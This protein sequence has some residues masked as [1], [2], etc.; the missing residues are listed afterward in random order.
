MAHNDPSDPATARKAQD[1]SPLVITSS[2]PPA[3]V[4]AGRGGAGNMLRDSSANKETKD[5]RG[6]S[7]KT[8]RSGS[9]VFV[10]AQDALDKMRS[11]SGR[12]R[13]SEAGSV[14]SHTS[15]SSFVSSTRG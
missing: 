10:R 5:A 8:E 14:K 4:S 3:R 2:D 7:Q 11:G 13:G 1:V 9:G 15:G 12:R 6:R